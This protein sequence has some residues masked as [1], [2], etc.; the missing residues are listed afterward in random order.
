M[1]ACAG[2]PGGVFR[3]YG[4][5]G[6]PERSIAI[7]TRGAGIESAVGE[8]GWH[9]GYLPSRHGAVF[10]FGFP[11]GGASRVQAI[12]R[13]EVRMGVRQVSQV[14]FATQQKRVFSGVQP[15]GSL[16]IGNY[17]GAISRFGLFQQGYECF[18]SVV[19]LHA[20]TVP[21]DPAEL[22]RR[23]VA[24]AA[25]FVAAGLDPQRACIFVQ[26]DNP[27]H[28]ELAWVL[29]CLA[30]F[31][32]LG[33]MTQFKDKARSKASVSAG[34]FTYP[35]LMA[36]DILLYDADVVPVGED[37][38]QHVELSRDLAERFNRRFGATFRVPE[39]LIPEQGGRIM[40]LTDPL[41]K[42][43]KS[44]E[45]PDSRI[46]VLDP[47]DEILRKF[48][49]AVTDSGRE[50]VY[51]PEAKPAVSN[52]MTI[53]SLFSGKSLDEVRDSYE[54]KGYSSFKS[55]LAELV[56]GRLRP[57]RERYSELMSSGEIE[58]ILKQGAQRAC[59]TSS[60]K[61]KEVRDKVGLSSRLYQ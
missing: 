11:K 35:V 53:Y 40:S 7:R 46:E 22:R 60:K 45:D 42:M 55:E 6:I 32:E 34:L 15:S 12:W 10:S 18:Y 27:N 3:R 1:K 28:P 9:R 16:H 36:A 8:A 37:Q 54:G 25:L 56:A 49:K 61:M 20:I 58:E 5:D 41:K 23:T 43:S 17:L 4:V 33:R 14:G 38:K 24:T 31:G 51:D 59:A 48:R 21:Q 57:V 44:D 39:P 2:K 26:S 52:L 50:I 13:S 47:P 30:T 29:E 19:D